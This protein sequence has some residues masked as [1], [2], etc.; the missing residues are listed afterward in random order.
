MNIGWCLGGQRANTSAAWWFSGEQCVLKIPSSRVPLLVCAHPS[1]FSHR[2]TPRS[3]NRQFSYLTGILSQCTLREKKLRSQKQKRYKRILSSEVRCD[4]RSKE[5]LCC[6]SLP[7]VVLSTFFR[8]PPSPTSSCSNFA[9]FSL[10]FPKCFPARSSSRQIHQWHQI[11][12][13][14]LF[15]E[16]QHFSLWRLASRMVSDKRPA[17]R[18]W[19]QGCLK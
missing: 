19:G 2:M 17:W 11:K 18:L 4:V 10:P 3:T 1:S 13:T 8:L 12:S 9:S 14:F 5:Y 15:F 6:D 16:K 7:Y